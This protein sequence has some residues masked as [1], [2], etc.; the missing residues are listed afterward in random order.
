MICPLKRKKRQGQRKIVIKQRY[1]ELS[2]IYQLQKTKKLYFKVA[3][4]CWQGE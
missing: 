1:K 3:C 4:L 2:N